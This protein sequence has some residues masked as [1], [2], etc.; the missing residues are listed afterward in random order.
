MKERDATQNAA[1]FMKLTEIE[2][3]SQVMKKSN[4]MESNRA[5]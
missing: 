4:V 3:Q 5:L 1:E 2:D